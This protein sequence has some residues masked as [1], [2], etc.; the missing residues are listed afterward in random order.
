MITAK[1]AIERR[2][3]YTLPDP[4]KT[5]DMRQRDQF[6]R[7]DSALKSHF[8]YRDD[9]LVSGEGYLR[10]QACNDSEQFAPDCIVAFGVNP[11]EIIAS[12]GYVI[13]DV[14]KP[15]DLVLEV[16]SRSTGRRDYTIKRDAY[17]RYRSKEYW[18][19]DETGGRYH[20]AALAG[21]TLV[22]DVYVPIPIERAADGA[23][24]GYSEVLGLYVCWDRGKLRFY[25]PQARRYLPNAEELREERDAAEAR[26]D[27]AEAERDA[28]RAAR[29][30]IEAELRRLRERIRRNGDTESQ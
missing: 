10:L 18:R 23:L 25:D 6:Y 7:I 19:F 21:D 8:K 28:E 30:A 13:S 12:N 16:A 14:G 26:A 29:L 5:H 1:P 20:D 2:R 11:E 3:A 22:N 4:P 27:S 17:A 9:V 24:R 15:P